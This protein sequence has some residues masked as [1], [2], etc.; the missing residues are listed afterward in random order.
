[1]SAGSVLRLGVGDVAVVALQNLKAQPVTSQVTGKHELL[2]T[3]ADGARLYVDPGVEDQLKRLRIQPGEEFDLEKMKG[4]WYQVRKLETGAHRT[5]PTPAPAP[6]ISQPPKAQDQRQ[7]TAAAPMQ[8]MPVP[9]QQERCYYEAI[10]ISLRVMEH[11]K[12]RGLII[13]PT[14]EDIRAIGTT[15]YIQLTRGPQQ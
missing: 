13:S 6:A 8:A 11:A 15:M 5:P 12:T 7:T 9:T 1:M 3:L 4:G 2:Y 14:F 10:D